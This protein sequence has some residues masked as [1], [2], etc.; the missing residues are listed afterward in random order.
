MLASMAAAA[1]AA[2]CSVSL[3]VVTPHLMWMGPSRWKFPLKQAKD[4]SVVATSQIAVSSMPPVYP[5]KMGICSIMIVSPTVVHPASMF[6][7]VMSIFS[8]LS[9][10]H[11]CASVI[12]CPAL[13]RSAQRRPASDRGVSGP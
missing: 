11:S 1:W 10:E 7:P 13:G 9:W 2:I 3:A 4:P 12:L 6:S 5:P 8:S